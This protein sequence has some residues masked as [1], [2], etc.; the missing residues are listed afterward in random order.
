MLF[1]QETMHFHFALE[2]ANYVTG[3][4]KLCCTGR[5]HGPILVRLSREY[6]QVLESLAC[7]P[8]NVGGKGVI[9]EPMPASSS[10]GRKARGNL[11]QPQGGGDS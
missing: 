4:I 9:V 8:Q 10:R 6:R 7:A 5:T 11:F 1:E 2:P 3:P